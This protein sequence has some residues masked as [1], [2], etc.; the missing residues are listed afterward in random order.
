MKSSFQL[1]FLA[2]FA[3]PHSISEKHWFRGI[4]LSIIR[5]KQKDVAAVNKLFVSGVTKGIW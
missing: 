3:K 2:F 5:Q 1:H 4:Y